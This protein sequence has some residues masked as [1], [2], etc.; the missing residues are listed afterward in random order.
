MGAWPKLPSSMQTLLTFAKRILKA[1]II[2]IIGIIENWAIGSYLLV[3]EI[4]NS[5]GAFWFSFD[6]PEG[7]IPFL[8]FFFA[9]IAVICLVLLVIREILLWRNAIVETR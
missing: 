4:S 8:F 1:T 9:W 3:R 2:P 7:F 5:S 6:H